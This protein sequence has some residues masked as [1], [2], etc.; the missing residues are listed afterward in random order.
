MLADMLLNNVY[1]K[2]STWRL[3]R[4]GCRVMI[5]IRPVTS[6][7]LGVLKNPLSSKSYILAIFKNDGNYLMHTVLLLH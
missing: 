5:N 1:F 3:K 4:T 7:V 2:R 6:W